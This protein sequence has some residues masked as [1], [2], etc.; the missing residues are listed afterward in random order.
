MADKNNK[1]PNKIL[2]QSLV[3]NDPLLIKALNCSDGTATQSI[4]PITTST[5]CIATSA[6]SN[7]ST[8]LGV[9]IKEKEREQFFL[10]IKEVQETFVSK[11]GFTVRPF[12][13]DI[14][15]TPKITVY[16]AKD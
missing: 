9:E 7:I 5:N 6:I 3:E 14:E 8:G 2:L 11:V 15:R 16:K 1:K 13:I 4:Y 10:A 12:K